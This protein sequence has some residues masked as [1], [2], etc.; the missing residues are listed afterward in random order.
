MASGIVY[1]G[2]TEGANLEEGQ[3][4]AGKKF[5]VAQRCP[6]RNHYLDLLKSNGGKIVQLEKQA[7][8][9]IADHLYKQCPPGSIS[10]RWIDQSIRNGELADEDAHR[11]GP[12]QNTTRDAGSLSR[13]IKFGRTPFT[14]EDDRILYKWV[15]D[16]EANG[17]MILGNELYKQLEAKVC[18][19][20]PVDDEC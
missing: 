6:S 10:Y 5:W 3:L 4:F 12:P 17:G 15:K 20:H 14:A 2:V 16:A 9:L 1:E 18:L 19:G 11:A 7:D 13:P 8:Y